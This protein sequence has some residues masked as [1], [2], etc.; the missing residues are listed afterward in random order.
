V[1]DE[2]VP[3]DPTLRQILEGLPRRGKKVFRFTDPRDGHAINANTMSCRVRD[4]AKRAGVKL[5][6]HSLRKGF[7]CRH[8]GRV[9][10]QVLQRLMRHA[11]I[12]TTMD[13]YANIDA[14]VEEAILGPSRNTS[15]NTR[16]EGQETSGTPLGVNPAGQSDCGGPAG[17]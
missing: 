4:L 3:L 12:K 15:R 17:G 2:W 8:A 1:E 13:Y 11:S 7:G 9:P 5:T 14:A 10:A 16:P 6:M